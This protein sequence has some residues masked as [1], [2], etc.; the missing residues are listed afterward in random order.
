MNL[1]NDMRQKNTQIK[2]D[3]HSALTGEIRPATG[4]L[5]NKVVFE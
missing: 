4:A 1:R 3:F 2:L 5:V